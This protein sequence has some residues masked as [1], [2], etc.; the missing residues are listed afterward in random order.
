MDKLAAPLLSLFQMEQTTA[1]V[2][3]SLR[4]ACPELP[5]WA[6]PQKDCPKAPL[7]SA[8]NDHYEFWQGISW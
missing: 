5:E 4:L 8:K 2:E 7:V 6:P 1:M 3:S